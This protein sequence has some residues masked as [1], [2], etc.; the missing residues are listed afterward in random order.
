MKKLLT[1]LFLLLFCHC[2][3][4]QVKY[5]IEL[6][7]DNETYLISFVS[8]VTYTF[9]QNK[10]VSGQVTIRMPH[11]I[12][13]NAF[14]V[15]NLTMETPGAN[16]QNNDI[17]RGP[18]EAPSWD[19]F[20]FA[21][22]TPG[23]NAYNFQAGVSI[24]VFSFKNG[25]E[26]CADSVYIIDNNNDPF[27]NNSLNVDISNTLVIFGGGFNNSYG[28][29]VGTGSAPGTPQTLCTNEMVDQRV[30]CDSVIYQGQTFTR[31]TTV[32][33]HYTSSIGC[34]SVFLTEILIQD[35]LMSTVD[36]AICEGDVFKG[37]AILQD[38]TVMQT[39]VS[40]QGCDSTVTYLIQVVQPSSSEQ[41][42]TVL[43]GQTVNGTQV[44][45]D[46]TIVANLVN[47]V[48]CDSVTTTHVT[49]YNVPTT[50]VNADICLGESYNGNFYLNDTSFVETLTGASGFDSLVVYN[51]DVHENYNINFY[52]DLCFGQPHT[53]GIV[54]ANDTVFYQNLHTV[55]GCDSI[56]TTTI[57]VVV[58]QYFITDT[59]V[60]MGQ[61]YQ[62][63]LYQNSQVFTQTITSASGC[64][65][66][67][68][69][70][71]LTVEPAVT[72]SISGITEICQGDET[73]LTA[74]GGDRFTWDNGST[75]NQITVT[76]AGSYHVTV[77]NGT[78]CSDTA[79]ITVAQSGLSA[80]ADVQHPRCHFDLS[81][82][83]QIANVNGGIEPYVYS[84]DGGN[85]FVT[86]PS[87]PNLSPGEYE[88]EVQ[89]QFGCYWKETV[90]IIAP[91]EIWVDAGVG[92]SSRLGETVKLQAF[93][94]LLAPD[95]VVWSPQEGLTCP[96]CLQTE[97][98]PLK[99][100]T[101]R[102]M[103]T[104]E[105]GCSSEGSVTIIVNAE[106]EVYVPNAF[107][108][109]GDG[110]NDSFTVFA[111]DNVLQ[112]RRM[113]VFE[114]WGG[115]VFLAENFYPNDLTSGWKGK[116]KGGD[117]PEGLYIWMAEVE[118]IDGKIKLF[119]GD[120]SLMR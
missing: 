78:G 118:F 37:V 20:S 52:A 96:T 76:E 7:P 79:S 115:Q 89:D 74:D 27:L 80:Q 43:P 36:T 112:V 21:L 56:I 10:V 116:W 92:Q 108:P 117:A 100:T 46:T 5:E 75:A 29:T 104:D 48:G 57:N 73:V 66:I 101:Y 103:V 45:S 30:G 61:L 2:L 44:F 54:Y 23:T 63:V 85:F 64:D 49:V 40:S 33:V 109:N 111:D 17:V 110:Y 28:G 90:E 22:T 107:S 18:A 58:P 65:S 12:G 93:T 69:Q 14:Q 39:Y 16:W 71:N 84:I 105:N 51:I 9:P 99:T 87:F 24:P 82:A 77:S 50:P 13:V 47:A 86:E 70:V 3:F 95:S 34:D 97:V 119:E 68:T 26:H 38:Q 55:F 59:S 42:V 83:I 19:Y 8:S 67:V 15:T 6:L 1:S 94:S 106:H 98:M 114:R 11:G 120:V 60:C 72:A 62:G 88:V 41:Q 91:Q 32:E 31:D 81:G 25:G 102:I 53:N 4:S 113:A 35:E